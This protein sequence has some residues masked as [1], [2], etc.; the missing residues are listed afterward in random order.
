MFNMV[1]SNIRT[2]A[3]LMQYSHGLT[4]AA[5]KKISSDDGESA[6]NASGS[7]QMFRC[8]LGPVYF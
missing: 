2:E 6:D 8:V 1:N 5:K 3:N 4:P 7:Y